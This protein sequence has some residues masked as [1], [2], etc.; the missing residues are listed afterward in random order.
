MNERDAVRD[1]RSPEAVAGAAVTGGAAGV[2]VPGEVAAAPVTGGPAAGVGGA[3]AGVAVTDE[4]VRVEGVHRTF[5]R[6]EHAVYAVRDVS[7]AA[8]RGELVALR[9]R[10]GAGKTTLLNLVGGLDRPDSGRVVVAGREVTGAGERELLELRRDRIGFVFQTF[11]LVPILSAAENVGVPLRLARVS[12]TEREER[13]AMLLELVGL[14]G[15]AAQRPYELSGGQQQRVAV[16]RALANE[17]DLLIADEPTGQLDSET[18]RSIMDLLRAVVHARGMTALVAT[19][20]PALI[21]LADR[22]LTLRDGH[23]L[24]T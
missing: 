12:A 18:G 21:D 13:V 1:G 3:A 24:P 22:V 11:G 17:P 8:G 5:G 7:F 4:V 19:H 20:D 14:G 9:G 16:A 2:G 15:H 23:L 6:G 10:S